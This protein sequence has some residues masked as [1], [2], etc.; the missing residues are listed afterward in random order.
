PAAREPRRRA[1]M[2]RHLW[3]LCLLVPLVVVWG[4]GSLFWLVTDRV[5]VLGQE[6]GMMGAQ[7]A[8]AAAPFLLLALGATFAGERRVE[9]ARR[10]LRRATRHGLLA[11]AGLWGYFHFEGYRYWAGNGTGGAN[12]GLGLLMLG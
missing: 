8:L 1:R 7:S 5:D 2:I 12:I 9:A 11:S 6:V 3:L 4:L 10:S